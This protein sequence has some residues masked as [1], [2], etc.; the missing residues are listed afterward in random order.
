MKKAVVAAGIVILGAGGWAT[1][2]WYTGKQLEIKI[3]EQVARYNEYLAQFAP[4]I[5][6]ELKQTA[7]Q[8]GFFSSTAH[9]IL[10]SP[11]NDS[12]EKLDFDI[13]ID[14]GPFPK[15]ALAQGH[16]LPK[17]GFI[18][19]VLAKT[20]TSAPAFA[21]TKD[22]PPI[23]TNATVAYS[24]NVSALSTIPAIDY[25]DNI[26]TVNFSGAKIKNQ[27][28]RNT[29]EIGTVL[30]IGSLFVI[31]DKNEEPA[32]AKFEGMMLDIVYRPVKADPS[33][34]P[35]LRNELNAHNVRAKFTIKSIS[36]KNENGADSFSLTAQDLSVGSTYAPG[37]FGVPLMDL[38]FNIK[39]AE[40]HTPD[41]NLTVTV[42]NLGYV[43]NLSEDK[44]SLA[45]KIVYTADGFTVNKLALG[46][47]AFGINLQ[48]LDG[49]AM[50]D[51]MG[52][53][54]Q[55]TQAALG[56]NLDSGAMNQ[57][58]LIGSAAQ[59][60][61]RLLEANPEL[62]IEPVSLKTDKG[63]STFNA[64]I[65]FTK[66]NNFFGVKRDDIVLQSIKSIDA[67][68]VVSKPMLTTLATDILMQQQDIDEAAATVQVTEAM[69]GL[70]MIEAMG[71]VKQDGDNI[72]ST[73]HYAD[74]V[75]KLNDQEFSQEQIK[76]LLQQAGLGSDSDDDDE[77]GQ[78]SVASAAANDY[79]PLSP[80]KIAEIV[81]N[82][83]FP[84]RLE[85]TPAGN[86]LLV[87]EPGE[88]HA[89]KVDIEFIDCDDGKFCN[90]MMARAEFK[91]PKP[92]P[93]KV[94][95]QMNRETRWIRIHLGEKNQ[96]VVEMDISAA[97]RYDGLKAGALDNML[98][99]FFNGA[100]AIAHDILGSSLHR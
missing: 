94:I 74:G 72:V 5:P 1:A 65:V 79:V 84:S 81:E 46:K 48:N 88:T 22:L 2:S 87:L 59:I 4:L 92:I 97:G 42:D 82:F 66:P 99:A 91:T 9:F 21:L 75:A 34:D 70:G 62:R 76:E 90:E 71:I 80:E 55:I 35:A 24:G 44:T 57:F 11:E 45:G 17:M 12:S 83:G 56:H 29:R 60:A 20:E 98:E 8:R 14:H 41:T 33:A 3:P 23:E 32:S 15:G 100:H 68:A 95:N 18:N 10:Y 47:T 51:L 85:T 36:A 69:Q 43:T 27:F 28:V 73:F 49:A 64:S 6:V 37:S 25:Q 86:P 38:S 7:Y 54:E 39:R 89:H 52:I 19:A 31:G 40:I 63:E 67:K 50:R 53:Y 77:D 61:M 16:F 26:S 96:V 30:D 13:K 58:A 78:E 93:L